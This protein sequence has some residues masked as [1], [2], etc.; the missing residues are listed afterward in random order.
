MVEI[1]DVNNQEINKILVKKEELVAVLP[2][3][4]LVVRKPR[5][6]KSEKE[7]QADI[8]PNWFHIFFPLS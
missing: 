3:G 5:K 1:K 7:K 8:C 6:T 4:G 2:K